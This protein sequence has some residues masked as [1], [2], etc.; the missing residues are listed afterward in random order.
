MLYI[1]IFFC[2]VLGEEQNDDDVQEIKNP[3]KVGKKNW[4]TDEE[5]FLAKAWVHVSTCPKVGNQQK[6]DSFWGRILEHFKQNVPDTL[7]TFHGLNTKWKNMNTEL[8]TFN[9]LYI[10]QVSF[11]LYTLYNFFSLYLLFV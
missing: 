8:N 9:G 3:G 4:T 7:R 5:V 11:K 1:Y 6:S 10:Q 2:F